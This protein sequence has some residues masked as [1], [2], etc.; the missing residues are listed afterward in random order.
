MHRH[1]AG[2]PSTTHCARQRGRCDLGPVREAP[3]MLAR[4]S[5]A[6]PQST[7][8]SALLT[9][10]SFSDLH[11][12][13]H[14]GRC[15]S[16]RFGGK[17]QPNGTEVDLPALIRGR[18]PP[19]LLQADPHGSAAR[20]TALPGRERPPMTRDAVLPPS[21]R[22]RWQHVVEVDHGRYTRTRNCIRHVTAFP[23]VVVALQD[24]RRCYRCATPHGYCA[25]WCVTPWRRQNDV[26][27]TQR[28]VGRA[29]EPH[30]S[31][32]SWMAGGRGMYVK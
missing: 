2:P 7:S 20:S 24:G 9:L 32:G 28:R 8:S 15:R 18:S 12:R 27:G 5:I 31:G 25:G 19:F 1:R 4:G 3:A 26:N 17:T 11:S 23:L 13:G 10:I 21:H 16:R 6:L 14:L 22:P 30:D 29:A